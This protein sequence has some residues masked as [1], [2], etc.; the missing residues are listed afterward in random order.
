MT[1]PE[2]ADNRTKRR[3]LVLGALGV[4]MSLA[5]LWFFNSNSFADADVGSG[6]FTVG[7][8]EYEF[9][10]TTCN[11]SLKDFIAAGVGHD[12]ET[13]FFV[14][15]SSTNLRFTAGTENELDPPIDG[16]MWFTSQG[17]IEW[18]ATGEVITIQA[19]VSDD[20]NARAPAYPAEIRIVCNGA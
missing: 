17:A 9:V 18:Q 14:S 2:Y 3:N 10:P 16:Q 5:G 20:R 1:W 4:M 12:G 19:M 6:M 8:Q 11:H 15:A 13:P 7:D